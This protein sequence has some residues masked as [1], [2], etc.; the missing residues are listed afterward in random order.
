VI[1]TLIV[2]AI[3]VG[4]A[5]FFLVR[6]SSPEDEWSS[7]Y[8][9]GELA[10]WPF[11]RAW[12]SARWRALR[13]FVNYRVLRRPLPVAPP[14]KLSPTTVSLQGMYKL[15]YTPG[16]IAADA[17]RSTPAF[18]SLTK[19]VSASDVLRVSCPCGRIVRIDVP[20]YPKLLCPA[21]LRD[22]TAEVRAAV[23]ARP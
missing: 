20:D 6:G 3:L 13:F 15:H 9:D 19:A 8:Y 4:L 5:L 22:M 7:D 16:A 1:E 2:L 21:C 10:L 11:L 23:A 18:A 17:A 14:A 12:A